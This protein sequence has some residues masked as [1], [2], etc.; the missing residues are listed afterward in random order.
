MKKI[1]ALLFLITVI[2]LE[3][4]KAQEKTLLKDSLLQR[5]NMRTEMDKTPIPPMD[6]VPAKKDNT[7]VDNMPIK[8]D[9][10]HIK[11]DSG[12]PDLSALQLSDWRRVVVNRPATRAG[13][14]LRSRFPIPPGH[15]D[16]VAALAGLGPREAV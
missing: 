8:R 5:D 1:I 7:R 12:N 4:T 15:A 11:L 13:Q 6:I 16:L 2:G 10:T 3:K 9:T 14:Y